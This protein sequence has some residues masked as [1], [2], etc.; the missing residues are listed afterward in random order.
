MK[1]RL[2]VAIP[3]VLAF[4][5]ASTKGQLDEFSGVE[6]GKLAQPIDTH[7]EVS[8]VSVTS[9]EEFSNVGS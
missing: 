9:V 3:A 7:L 2:V 8:I 5:G 4:L 1:S 6:N